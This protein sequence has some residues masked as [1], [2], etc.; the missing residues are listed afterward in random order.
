MLIS[1][2]VHS[3]GMEKVPVMGLYRTISRKYI[4]TVLLWTL[5]IPL[6]GLVG[7]SLLKFTFA[8]DP[9]PKDYRKIGLAHRVATEVPQGRGG[10]P[11][12]PGADPGSGGGRVWSDQGSIGD[13]LW[14]ER[15]ATSRRKVRAS[16]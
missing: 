13:R 6:G 2:V 14:I 4:G 5:L 11:G 7:R 12:L 8:P 3:G 10:G 16:N 9:V 1:G 15:T